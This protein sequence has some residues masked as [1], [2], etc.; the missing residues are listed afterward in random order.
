M[1]EQKIALVTGAT[2]GIGAAIAAQLLKD[3]FMPIVWCR[4]IATANYVAEYL[5]KALSREFPGLRV[6]AATGEQV[7]DERRALVDA[8][9]PDVENGAA[10]VAGLAAGLGGDERDRVGFVQQPQFA[11]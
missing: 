6:I 10:A 7:D 8:L 3:G 2:R 5:N 9:G 4:Y 1:S 11:L